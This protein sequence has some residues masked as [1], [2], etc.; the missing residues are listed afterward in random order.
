[1]EP[2]HKRVA[3]LDVH[4]MKPV[5]TILIEE[6][7]RTLTK[8]TRQFGGFKR[9]LRALTAWL[10][11]QGVQLVVMESTGIYWKSVYA[12]LEAAGIPALVVNARHIKNVPGRKTDVAD[13]EWLAQL[14]RFGG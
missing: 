5:A 2:I 8:A 14:A 1:M 13:S 9:D 4:H 12:A 6:D 10:G 11:E 3:G 7:E